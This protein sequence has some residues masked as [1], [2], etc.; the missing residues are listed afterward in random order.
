MFGGGFLYE[1]GALDFAGGAVVHMNAGAAAVAMVILLGVRSGYPETPM[2]PAQPALDRARHRHPLVRMG[3][4]QRRLG[5][6]RDGIA[7]Q[8]IMNTFLAASAAM[9]S[10]L[11]VEKILS[12]HATT[13][14]AASGCG[15]RSGGDHPVCRLGAGPR[16]SVV[17]GEQPVADPGRRHDL[18]R[19]GVGAELA[20]QQRDVGAQGV[21]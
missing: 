8:A 18:W 3:R 19:P 12:G 5:P 7:A 14:G 9:L 13:L 6:R 15:R 16:R 2:R 17:W 21:E 20:P 1:L 11:V 4:L 10:W